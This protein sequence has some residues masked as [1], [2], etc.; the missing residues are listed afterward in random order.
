MCDVAAPP[1]PVFSTQLTLPPQM[2]EYDTVGLSGQVQVQATLGALGAVSGVEG[3][4]GDGFGDSF[5]SRSR[6]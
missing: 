6:L 1:S 2:G 3:T 5:K 4:A